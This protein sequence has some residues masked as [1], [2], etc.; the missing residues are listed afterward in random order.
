[1]I[2][3]APPT[4]DFDLG[5]EID[6][7][8]ETVRGYAQDRIAPLA[9]RIDREDWFPRELWPEMGELGLHGITVSEEDG[10]AGLGYL[11]HV[12]AL[13]E[14]SRASASIVRSLGRN[15][16]PAR[17]EASMIFLHSCSDFNGQLPHSVD[18]VFV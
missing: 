18:W 8:R 11:A 1:M 14:V 7:L 17:V 12:V 5:E 4:F 10:G 9:D 3:N 13:E 6:M 2:P 16:E 15:C